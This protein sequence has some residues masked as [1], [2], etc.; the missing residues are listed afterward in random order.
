MS[1][2][3]VANRLLAVIQSVV[4]EQSTRPGRRDIRCV[5][6]VGV[7]RLLAR[8]PPGSR[9]GAGR[10]RSFLAPGPY[11]TSQRKERSAQFT[12]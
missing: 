9:P 2:T 7:Q 12:K 3:G 10:R 5:V 8:L 1:V 4:S 6:V 11:P